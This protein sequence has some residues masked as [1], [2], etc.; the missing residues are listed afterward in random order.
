MKFCKLFFLILSFTSCST[1][2]NSVSREPASFQ[3]CLAAM[4]NLINYKIYSPQNRNNLF[5]AKTLEELE[6]TYGDESFIDIQRGLTN[7]DIIANNL[8]LK[9][10]LA[11]EMKFKPIAKKKTFVSKAEADVIYKAMRDAKVNINHDC[12]DPK[13]TIGF[14]FGRATI[15]HMEALIREVHPDAIRKVWI[16][17]DMGKWGHHVATIIKAENGWLAL[18]TNMGRVITLDEWFIIVH[19]EKVKDANEIMN[20]V[21]QAGRFSPY[22]NMSYNSFDLFNTDRLEFNKAQDFYRGYFHDYFE[23]LDKVVPK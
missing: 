9:K 2:E 22:N 23:D 14:C 20:F 16:A 4:N 10:L 6:A 17:G 5:Q 7:E 19:R 3:S 15:A 21:T 11:G 12:Y 8:N 13:G 18:D 1:W